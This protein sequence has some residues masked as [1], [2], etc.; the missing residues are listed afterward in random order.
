M[1]PPKPD[2]QRWSLAD[3][4][5]IEYLPG[6]LAGPLAS[7]LFTLLRDRVPWR[8]EIT[9]FNRPVPRLTAWFADPG[10]VYRYSGITHEPEPWL[11]ELCDLRRR[12]EAAAGAKFNSVL[13]NYYRDGNDSVSWHAD[14]E[15]ELGTNP[16]IASVSLGA[17][18]RFLLKHRKNR[19]RIAIDLESGS[20]L[21][22]AGTLQHHWLHCIP[23]TK[24][25]VGPRINLTFRRLLPSTLS[26]D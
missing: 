5:V 10:L 15:P 16:V 25:K 3:G 20:L 7:Q 18:R 19:E 14:D 21:I 4:G 1:K 13:L 17:V 22:M 8:Q 11:P 12:V 9:I 24:A 6:F 2:R 26:S 23:K